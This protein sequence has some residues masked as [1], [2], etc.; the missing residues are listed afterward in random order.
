LLSYY[1]H[2]H[3]P[4]SSLPFFDGKKRPTPSPK[5]LLNQSASSLL[6]DK[7][8][9]NA[10]SVQKDSK[11]ATVRPTKRKGNDFGSGTFWNRPVQPK[12]RAHQEYEALALHSTPLSPYD[13]IVD[14]GASHVLF[15]KKHRKLLTDV[16]LSKPNHRPFATLR[17]ANGQ[18][19]T[20]IGQG[21]FRIKK[22]AV[23]A[24][25]FNDDD[26]VHNLLGIAPFADCGCKAV[27][28]ATDFNLYHGQ[29]LLLCGKRHSANLWH[30]VL[31]VPSGQETTKTSTLGTK[32]EHVLLLNEDTRT[33][34][35]Y[36][37]FIHACLGSPP[38]STFLR[39]VERG[40]LS[41]PSQFPRL[42]ARM[43][44]KH[45]PESEATTRGHL[46]KTPTSQPHALS[47]AVS[48]RRRAH[49]NNLRHQ[50]GAAPTSPTTKPRFLARRRAHLHN[51]RQQH[52]AAPTSPTT[53]PPPPFDPTKVPL[54]TTLHLDYTGRMPLRGSRG[55][56]YFLVATWGSYIHLRP[57]TTLTG[58]ETAEALEATI[59]FFRKHRVVL[60]TIRM[61]NQTS[62][63]IRA[64]ATSLDLKWELVNPYQKEPN[65]AERAIRTSKNHIIA[66]RAGF[67]HDCSVTFL[68]RYLFQIELTLNLIHPFE[69]DPS[70]SAH[71]GLFGSRFDFSR[72]PIAPVGAK[73]LVWNSPDNRGSW[74]DHGVPGIYLGPAMRHFRGFEVWIPQ[75]SSKRVSST[76]WWFVKLM[77]PD[78][79]LLSSA[80]LRIMYPLSTER[81]DPEPNGSDLLGR[82]SSS[83]KMAFVAALRWDTQ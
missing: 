68:D 39:A 64:M 63:E 10:D 18:V 16:Q 3:S 56:L 28:T 36:V 37:Q 50:H 38:P 60:D 54:S 72:H 79:D 27:F 59:L 76:I 82:V 47:E 22:I 57:L 44:R 74:S 55:T 70:I 49:L 24:F 80:N 26:L 78:S 17:A 32:T 13:L 34:Q 52:G 40:Y 5:Q 81:I 20:A 67:H 69:Y 71:E 25:I 43:V 73:V 15:Q 12:R 77:S 9:E 48:A 31:P 1:D 11:T 58:K 33:D 19:L 41:H 6:P 42:T 53:K 29:D 14:T 66:V 8:V 65:R 2:N 23:V 35:K 51:L 62:P 61:D 75:T 30:I 46:N 83:L 4:A 7:I 45:M 21:I